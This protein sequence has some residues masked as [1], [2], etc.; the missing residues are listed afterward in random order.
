MKVINGIIGAIAILSSIYLILYP[1]LTFVHT[2]WIAT[3][4][5]GIF[6][7]CSIVY[8]SVSKKN[9]AQNANYG[10]ATG[11]TSLIVGICAAAFSVLAIFI[12][13]F[14]GIIDIV[15]LIA[16]ALWLII[17]GIIEIMKAIRL[18]N[19]TTSKK[20]ILDLILGIFVLL[21]G[22]YGIFH[23]LVFMKTIGIMIG[24]MIMAYGIKQIAA[25]F[26]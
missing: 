22:I 21:F 4:V 26:E 7:I 9:N 2:G 15:I 13:S 12:P 11:I 25:I 6:G 14:Q 20:W 23:L 1:G 16:F 5:L 3:M 19:M 10:K 18:K 8:Y 17:D 24:I